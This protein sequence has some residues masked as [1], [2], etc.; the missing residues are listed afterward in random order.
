M[1]ALDNGSKTVTTAGT[2]VQ[3]SATS[4]AVES[5]TIQP[6]AANTGT[7]Y[8]G[9]PSVSSSNGTRLPSPA[10]SNSSITFTRDEDGI[11][12][13]SDIWLDASVSGEGVVFTYSVSP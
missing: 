3:L 9:G 10:T 6:K 13:L 12:E 1:G 5:V 8:V 7:I 4:V 11:D 2:R